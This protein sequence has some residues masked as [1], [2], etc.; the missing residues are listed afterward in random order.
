MH[1][2]GHIDIR[3][4]KDKLNCILTLIKKKQQQQLK[5]GMKNLYA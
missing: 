4:L 1:K 2:C 5:D 3:H